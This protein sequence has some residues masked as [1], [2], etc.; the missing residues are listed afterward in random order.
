M[1]VFCCFVVVSQINNNNCYTLCYCAK[2]GK[3]LDI[4]K[5]MA[6]SFW[7]FAVAQQ[8]TRPQDYKWLPPSFCLTTFAFCLGVAK[9][10]LKHVKE[11]FPIPLS[12]VR[13]PRN[14][15]ARL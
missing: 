5:Q 10:S 9:R 7:G 14:T 13:S 3:N 1:C 12:V 15:F 4:Y 2:Y 11:L 8:T 6:K